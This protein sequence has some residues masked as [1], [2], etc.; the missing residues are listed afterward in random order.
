MRHIVFVGLLATLVLP[1]LA[2]DKDKKSKDPEGYSWEPNYDIAKLK[3]AE[4]G[5]LLFMDFWFEG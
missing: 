5:K 2:G 3:A 1:A 4:Q